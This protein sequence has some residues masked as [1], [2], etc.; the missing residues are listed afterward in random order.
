MNDLKNVNEDLMVS[1]PMGTFIEM[2]AWKILKRQE[3]GCSHVLKSSIMTANKGKYPE[4]G[5]T[6]GSLYI[7]PYL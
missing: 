5:L 6:P 3:S 1:V 2:N 4:A 7:H